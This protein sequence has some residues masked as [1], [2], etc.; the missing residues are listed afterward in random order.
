MKRTL[1]G[2]LLVGL[3]GGPTA[4]MAAVLYT[5]SPDLPTNLSIPTALGVL[6]EGSNTISGAVSAKCIVRPSRCFTT[7]DDADAFS[8]VIADDLRLVSAVLS[9]SNFSGSGLAF[10]G[11]RSSTI[12]LFINLSGNVAH[13]DVLSSPVT[14]LQNYQVSTWLV[15]EGATARFDWRLD[16]VAER[17][18]VPEPC[19]IVLLGLGLAG[20]GLRRCERS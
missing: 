4:A 18:P 12:P 6:L 11:V 2:V 13:L 20:L 7:G 8:F 16:L 15:S 17:V 3:M 14:G 19:T 9:I 5:E 1:W 10:V